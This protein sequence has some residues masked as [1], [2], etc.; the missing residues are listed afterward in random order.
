MFVLT[1][2]SIFALCAQFDLML[3]ID[4]CASIHDLRWDISGRLSPI[5][6]TCFLD[7]KQDVTPFTL[8]LGLGVWVDL[9]PP[10]PPYCEG[11]LRPLGMVAHP[12]LREVGSTC[13]LW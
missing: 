8:L 9:G 3:R 7:L 1:T 5:G 13:F 11:V 4:P 2:L 12:T 10:Q 6:P